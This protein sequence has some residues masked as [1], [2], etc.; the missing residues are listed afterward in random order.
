MTF[1]YREMIS[2][3]FVAGILAKHNLTTGEFARTLGVSTGTVQRWCKGAF[4]T[5]RNAGDIQR[6]DWS[7]IQGKAARKQAELDR[8][9]EAA[10]QL[11]IPTPNS[12][13]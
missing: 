10:M 13:K 6:I 2:G 5:K 4:M 3:A 12:E 1:K 8:A 11:Y 7:K 9:I